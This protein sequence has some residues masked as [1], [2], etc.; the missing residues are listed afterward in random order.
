M[1]NQTIT[2]FNLI[3]KCLLLLPCIFLLFPARIV[4]AKIIY[5]P[6]NYSTIQSAIDAALS[7]DEIRVFAGTYYENITLKDGI[8]LK[9]EDPQ[10]TIIDGQ[11]K[12]SVISIVS[13][14][15]TRC[16]IIGFTLTNAGGGGR[17]LSSGAGNQPGIWMVSQ[18]RNG[19]T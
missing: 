15:Q 7:G 16:N 8:S 6:R 5:V 4:I 9:G 2:K 11:K 12:N 13:Y 19:E 10:T 18:I 1:R 17:V 3:F 14:S